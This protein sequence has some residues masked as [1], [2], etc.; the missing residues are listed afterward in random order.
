MSAYDAMGGALRKLGKKYEFGKNHEYS[1]GTSARM[2][3]IYN[4]LFAKQ[5]NLKCRTVK[6]D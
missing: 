3:D 2:C 5:F 4:V 6:S 1:D